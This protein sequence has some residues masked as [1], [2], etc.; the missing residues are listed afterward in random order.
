[1]EP[2]V[3]EYDWSDDDEIV[4][5][6]ECFLVGWL[7]DS[8]EAA[9]WEECKVEHDECDGG[10]DVIKPGSSERHKGYIGCNVFMFSVY[11]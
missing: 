9:E 6:V 11:A 2:F 7:V 8:Y 10:D 5:D 3:D 4:D 1:M